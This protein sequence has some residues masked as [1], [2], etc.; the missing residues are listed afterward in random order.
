MWKVGGPRSCFFS[1]PPPLSLSWVHNT[2]ELLSV[3]S[4]HLF[5][6]LSDCRPLSLSLSFPFSVLSLSLSVSVSSAFVER[7]GTFRLGAAKPWWCRFG[8]LVVVVVVELDLQQGRKTTQVK[9]LTTSLKRFSRYFSFLFFFSI[10][11]FPLPHILTTQVWL[12]V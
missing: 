5:T 1:A 9:L 7:F 10:F 12:S 3:A 6:C 11:F 4:E 2:A 8:L